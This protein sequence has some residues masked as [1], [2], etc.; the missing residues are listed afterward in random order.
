MDVH[1]DVVVAAVVVMMTM[2]SLYQVYVVVMVVAVEVVLLE[3]VVLMLNLMMDHVLH[4]NVKF[5]KENRYI[6]LLIL[7]FGFLIIYPMVML[8]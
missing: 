6:V 3:F 4:L 8:E 5:D 7:M 2:M 1:F